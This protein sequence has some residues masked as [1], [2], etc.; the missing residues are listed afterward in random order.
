VAQELT[1]KYALIQAQGKNLELIN[2]ERWNEKDKNRLIIFRVITQKLSQSK[3]LDDL[4]AQLRKEG[5]ETLFKHKGETNELQ[6]ISFRLGPYKYKGSAI[7]RN[8]SLKGL[9]R[10]LKQQELQKHTLRPSLEVRANQ[11]L[12][13]HPTDEK[14][15]LLTNL[16]D[17]KTNLHREMTLP[18]QLLLPKKR[19]R[20]IYTGNKLK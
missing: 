19:N 11:R 20:K 1:L 6:G 4:K 18:H 3:D 12:K 8:Y 9:E 16:L 15:N 5:I 14:T 7:D 17:S 10:L 2:S 13:P